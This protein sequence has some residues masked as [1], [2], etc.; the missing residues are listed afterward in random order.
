[1]QR[2]FTKNS[3]EIY[4]QFLKNDFFKKL[5]KQLKL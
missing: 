4:K 1:M 5:F 3:F 2:R